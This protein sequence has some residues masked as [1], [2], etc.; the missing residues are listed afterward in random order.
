[1][2]S[3]SER[4]KLLRK[5]KN[6]T[7]KQVAEMI[8]ITERGYR[9]YEIEGTVPVYAVLIVL[10]DFFDISLDYLVGRSDDPTRR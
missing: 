4:I 10:A 6:L 5:E 8:G 7:Q 3:F 9:N 2:A 1:M